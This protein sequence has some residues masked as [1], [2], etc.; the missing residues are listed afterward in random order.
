MYLNG[1]GRGIERVTNIHHTTVMHWIRMLGMN[2]RMRPRRMKF[3]KLLTWMNCKRLWAKATKNLALDCRESLAFGHPGLGC[4]RPECGNVQALV[5]DCRA[6][7][8]FGMERDGYTV[9]PVFIEDDPHLLSKTYM[10]REGETHK[11]SLFGTIAPQDVV[12][13][14]S[15]EMLSVLCV[16]CYLKDGTV[17]IPA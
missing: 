1:M 3:Q 5:V 17:H 9:Y 6:G 10:T 14:K 2:S 11:A 15:I 16:C 13:P 4:G 8:A 7:R 12:L